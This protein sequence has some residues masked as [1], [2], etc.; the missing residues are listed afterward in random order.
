MQLSQ[1]LL[2]IDHSQRRD[3]TNW[4]IEQQK[5]ITVF[6]DKI[7]IRDEVHIHLDGF[8]NRHIYRIWGLGNPRIIIKKKNVSLTCQCLV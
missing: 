2:S 7:I 6:V 4:I 1:Y 5:V 3:F 8:V